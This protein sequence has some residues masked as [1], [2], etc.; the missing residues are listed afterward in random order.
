[1]T[2]VEV[3]PFNMDDK[4]TQED[5]NSIEKQKLNLKPIDYFKEIATLHLD[6]VG[7]GDRYYLQD[8]G[9]Y[10]NELTD[11][12]Y[13]LRLRFPGGRISNQN[14]LDIAKIVT[15]H[16]LYIILTA[17]SGMQLHG[18]DE[19]NIIEIFERIDDLGINSWQTFGDNV[20]NVATDVFD[21]CGKYNIIEVYPYIQQMQEFILKVPEYVGLLPRRISTG[22][23]GSYANGGSFFASDLYFALAKKD[24]IYGFNVYMGGKNT[25]LALDANIFLEKEEVVEFFK[26]FVITFKEHGLRFDRDRTRLFHLLE[27]I[28]IEKFKSY[29]KKMYKKDFSQKGTIAL[30]KVVFEEFEELKNGEYSFC[31]HS[32]FARISAKELFDIAN[33]SIENNYEVRIGTD[34]QLYI[35][36]LK[37]KSFPLSHDNDN[38]TIL[39][40]AGSEFCPYSYWNIKDETNF[41]PLKRI[42]EHKILIG[43]SGCLRGCAKHQHSDM[44]LVGLRSSMYGTSQKTARLYLGAQYTLGTQVAKLIFLAI[45]LTHLKELLNLIIDEFENSIYDDFEE[46]SLHILNHLS[47][48]FLA[49]WFLGKIETKKDIKLEVGNEIDLLN[50]H[51]G[52]LEFIKFLNDDFSEAVEFQSIKL[53]S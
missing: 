41:L 5:L 9:L 31:Y 45:P 25:E 50:K 22:I 23:S 30:E 17:R 48:N 13:M 10:N 26:A 39:A 20:R 47:A 36:G 21:G 6:S 24:N 29:I 16:D 14:L 52:E 1:M 43:F 33:L 11:D 38:R 44:G 12:E 28:G 8:F 40:C 51:F 7:N 2:K 15:E 42:E 4:E 49:L 35:F 27:D 19:D 18:L 53:W 32:K 3:K 37:D 46:F 34:Q